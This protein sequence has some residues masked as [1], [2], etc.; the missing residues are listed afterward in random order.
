MYGLFPIGLI[1]ALIFYIKNKKFDLPTMLLLIP[2]VIIGIFCMFEIPYYSTI[3]LLR[4]SIP[5]RAILALGFIDIL[6][7]MRSLSITDKSPKLFISVIISIITDI[8]LILI[9]HFMNPMYVGKILSAG[10]FV[11]CGLLFLFALEYNTKFGKYLF[12]YSIIATMIACGFTVNPICSGTDMITDSKLYQS[13]KEINE[14]DPGIWLVDSIEFPAPNYL[15]MAGA[16]TINATNIYPNLELW[17]S[18]DKENKY[19][20]VY[21]R[22]AHVYIR[23]VPDESY[24]TDKFVVAGIGDKFEL[25]ITPDELKEMNVKYIFTVMVMEDF[26]SD[27]LD[28]ELIYNDSHNNHIYRVIYK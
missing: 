19:E 1:C 28:F 18:L 2:Y 16:P 12:T 9:C 22:Y 5:E 25:Y 7:L 3:T 14:T 8:I 23:I 27:T 13:I 20:Y 21:N 11:M 26:R 17:K 4:Y 15:A 6:I 10:L 24:I